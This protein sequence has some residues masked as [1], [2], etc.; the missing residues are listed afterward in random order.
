MHGRCPVAIR[1][2]ISGD[3]KQKICE[4]KLNF[5]KVDWCRKNGTFRI[6]KKIYENSSVSTP[7]KFWSV[8][9]FVINPLRRSPRYRNIHFYIPCRHTGE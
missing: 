9:N 8:L 5:P 1:H 6:I 3:M 2:F 4:Q 7:I